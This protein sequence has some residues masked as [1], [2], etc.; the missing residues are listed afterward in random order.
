MLNKDALVEKIKENDM[1]L[2]SFATELGINYSTLYRKLNGE[3]DFTRSE[4]QISKNVLKLDVNTADSIFLN[5]NL[6]KRKKGGALFGQTN[7]KRA[8]GASFKTST[9]PYA[10]S[11]Q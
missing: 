3:S 5:R 6:R 9:A 4:I 8:E 7:Q 2:E 10:L 1:T 11:N